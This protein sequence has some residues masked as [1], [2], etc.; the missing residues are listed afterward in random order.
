MLTYSTPL[1]PPLLLALVW[2][3]T[4][5]NVNVTQL[6][7]LLALVRQHQSNTP[8]HV[9]CFYLAQMLLNAN[10]T[11]LSTLLALSVDAIGNVTQ[12]SLSFVFVCRRRC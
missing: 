4:L 6:S 9:V 8:E 7:T 11:Q 5:L 10:M 1:S 3:Q 12:L 2:P